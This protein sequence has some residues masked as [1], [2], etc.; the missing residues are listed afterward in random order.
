MSFQRWSSTLCQRCFNLCS[1]HAEARTRVRTL[2]L[3]CIDS[4]DTLSDVFHYHTWL[5]TIPNGWLEITN[6]L[7]ITLKQRQISTLKQCQISTLKQRRILTF[8]TTS[9]FNVE[10]TSDFNVETTSYFNVVS[11]SY[12][13]GF[14]STSYFNV[15]TT[16]YFNTWFVLTKSN[17]FSTWKFDVVTTLFQLVFA[18]WELA[19][20]G[21][22]LLRTPGP[23]SWCFICSNVETRLSWTCHVS[24]LWIRASLC[25][26]ILRLNSLFFMIEFFYKLLL[27]YGWTIYSY[28][29]CSISNWVFFFA[30]ITLFTWHCRLFCVIEIRPLFSRSALGRKYDRGVSNRT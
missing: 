3:L 14:F 15:E 6:C 12:F 26:S 10:R 11:T 5:C 17:A 16:S 2:R 13:N 20:T 29:A 22:L 27:F 9:D 28:T 21:S 8:K 18:C 1:S 7:N 30:K 24:G 25:T 19:N 4:N 23:V